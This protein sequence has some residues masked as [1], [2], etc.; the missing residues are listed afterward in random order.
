MARCRF[1]ITTQ[2]TFTALSMR[3]G[4]R[5]DLVELMR[6]HD[7]MQAPAGAHPRCR[8]GTSS[9]SRTSLISLAHDLSKPLF[10]V[11]NSLLRRG[12]ETRQA[13]D[14]VLARAAIKA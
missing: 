2:A 3:L 12:L 4:S 1:S 7:S 8:A 11:E 9:L 10:L 13:N 5:P 14:N 6:S